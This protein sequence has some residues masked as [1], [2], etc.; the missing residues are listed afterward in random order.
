MSCFFSWNRVVVDLR[1]KAQNVIVNTRTLQM[2]QLTYMLFVFV[3]FVR[4]VL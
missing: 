4:N 2:R 3:K 1:L